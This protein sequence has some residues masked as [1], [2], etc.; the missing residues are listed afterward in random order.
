MTGVAYGDPLS[1]A[2]LGLLAGALEVKADVLGLPATA[3]GVI[4]AAQKPVA[5]LLRLDATAL[6]LSAVHAHTV[7][8]GD[9]GRPGVNSEVPEPFRH[10][11]QDPE[12]DPALAL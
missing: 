4:A 3:R 8:A 9:A 5:V 2:A 10:T 12:S 11:Q 1:L 6:S 7:M